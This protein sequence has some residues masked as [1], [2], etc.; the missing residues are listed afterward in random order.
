M[1]D[2]SLRVELVGF[3]VPLSSSLAN[4]LIWRVV[5]QQSLKGIASTTQRNVRGPSQSDSNAT[6]SSLYFFQVRHFSQFPF[7]VNGQFSPHV[8]VGVR[9]R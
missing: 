2:L 1:Q 3:Q 6:E 8:A 5:A 7:L 4:V 9:L